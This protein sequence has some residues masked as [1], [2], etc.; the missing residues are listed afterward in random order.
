[1][2]EP[3]YVVAP[4]LIAFEQWCGKQDPHAPL[5][6]VRFVSNVRMLEGLDQANIL[7]LSGWMKRADWRQIYNRALS[8]G[9]ARS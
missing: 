3:L 9:G 5:P 7:F 8:L 2:S 4:S 6:R 1:M